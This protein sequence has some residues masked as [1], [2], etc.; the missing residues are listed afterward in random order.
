[1]LIKILFRFILIKAI[2]QTFLSIP[3]YDNEI[4][5]LYDFSFK[6]AISNNPYL[7][8][9]FYDPEC[10]YCQ[11]FA[12]KYQKISEILHNKQLNVVIGK[13]DATLEKEIA[14]SEKIS[15]YPTIKLFDKGSPTVYKG[16]RSVSD[17][18]NWLEQKV[19]KNEK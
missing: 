19:N 18:V 1:M 14:K 13:I 10:S 11:E 7:L 6:E 5:N 16:D 2:L 12:P 17:I 3:R 4:Q 9:E 15:G 8:V